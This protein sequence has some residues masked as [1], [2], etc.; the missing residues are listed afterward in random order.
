M[1]FVFIHELLRLNDLIKVYRVIE[2]EC[3]L[4]ASER[5]W[6][7][8]GS[9]ESVG[10]SGEEARLGV[11]SLVVCKLRENSDF[12]M[13]LDRRRRGGKTQTIGRDVI[14]FREVDGALAS[15]RRSDVGGACMVSLS[16]LTWQ[17]N[18][19]RPALI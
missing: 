17:P 8:K 1:A 10:R 19:K 9:P 18:A 7:R 15:R 13:D 12:V 3:V 16:A 6:Q 11:S 5:R 2:G 14:F 4:Y